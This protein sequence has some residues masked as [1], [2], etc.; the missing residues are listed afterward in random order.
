MNLAKAT[1]RLAVYM[2][3][4]GQGDCSFVVPPADEGDPILFDCADPYV[5]SRFVAN[6]RITR[7]AAV[8]T[9]H[10]DRDHIRGILPFLKSFF[11]NGGRVD[12]L[13]I[14]LDRVPTSGGDVTIR[15]LIEQALEWMDTPPHEGFV[16]DDPRRFEDQPL[17]ILGHGDWTIDAVLPTYAARLKAGLGGARDTNACS[18]VLRVD[19]V[20]YTHLTLPTIYSV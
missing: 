9:S 8:V 2:L 18:V 1:D 17:R 19:P 13:L 16:V 3:D 11:S 4:V 20:S 12:R 7:L 15:A 6:H 10:L 5:A 14:G